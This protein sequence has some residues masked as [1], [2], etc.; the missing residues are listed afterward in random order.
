MVRLVGDIWCIE[1]VQE[2]EERRSGSKKLSMKD[3]CGRRRRVLS[4]GDC[5]LV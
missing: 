1:D 3:N 4:G 2:S 5:Y